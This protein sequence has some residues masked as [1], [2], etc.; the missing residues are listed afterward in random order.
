MHHI[1]KDFFISDEL[2]CSVDRNEWV[3]VSVC[4]LN[5]TTT[6]MLCF[7]L[8][9]KQRSEHLH[10]SQHPDCYLQPQ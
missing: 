5:L 6:T 8:A 9:G 3:A 7:V 4:V 1:K 2:R 10:D